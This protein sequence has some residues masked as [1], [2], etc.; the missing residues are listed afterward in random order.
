M[1]KCV[2]FEVRAG[3]LNIIYTIFVF[4]WLREEHRLGVSENRVLI[5]FV[6]LRDEVARNEKNTYRTAS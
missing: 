1:V 2:F 3:F 5:I 4:E 6:S